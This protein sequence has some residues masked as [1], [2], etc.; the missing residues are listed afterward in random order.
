MATHKYLG[1]VILLGLIFGAH[2]QAEQPEYTTTIT[3]TH[4][5]GPIG[6]AQPTQLDRSTIENLPGGDHTKMEDF[7]SET[8]PGGVRG[9]QQRV[10][11]NQNEFGI[12]Y[13]VDG[14]LLPP[15]QSEALSE[16][17]SLRN[18]EHI[19][20]LSGALPAQF[21]ERIFSLVDITTRSGAGQPQ[22]DVEIGYGSYR[23]FAPEGS[24][25]GASRDGK[26]RYFMTANYWQT[27]RGLGTPEPK[28]ESTQTQG[29]TD[30]YHDQ[31]HSNNEFV[32]LDWLPNSRNQFS[33][34][35]S[36][37]QSYYQIPVLPASFNPTDSFF[38]PNTTDSFGNSGYNYV[39][40]QTNDTQSESN[41]LIQWVW[42]N[43]ISQAS[44]LKLGFYS[45]YNQVRFDNDPANDL[46]ALKLISGSS[47]SSLF[48]NRHAN[49]SGIQGDYEGDL[50]LHQHFGAGFKLSG[51]LSSGLVQV[52]AQDPNNSGNVLSSSDSEPSHDWM[53]GVYVQDEIK[54]TE[55]LIL[56]AGLR[57]DAAQYHFSADATSHTQWEPRIG[58]SYQP[59]L[60]TRLHLFYARLF[61][62][63][64]LENLHQAFVD[65]Q[66]G[67]TGS[68]DIKPE[69][70]NYYEF[71]V[72]Q[73]LIA[74]QT[75]HATFYYKKS[76]DLLDDAQL[77]NTSLSQPF[78]WAQGYAYG[79]KLS[80]E[81]SLT[82]HIQDFV[83]YAYGTARGKN[84]SGGLFGINPDELP[85][86][87]TYQRLDHVQHHTLSSG[88]IYN[89]EHA[90][91]S[92]MGLFGSGL[93]TGPA[94]SIEL[95]SHLS[96]NISAG[97]RF[98][99]NTAWGGMK[100]SGDVTNIFNNV[101]PITIANGFNGS[102]YAQGR[103]FALHLANEF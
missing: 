26:F 58:L 3:D 50:G 14:L 20:V 72:D 53:E 79:L 45:T 56:N 4:D 22:A 54:W 57:F 101:Y 41:E 47:P 96:F 42:S 43:Q 90:W 1:W 2:A 10:Y 76:T 87:N 82:S 80:L 69:K 18:V 17:L 39:P 15:Q 99:K 24:L 27:D 34:L 61:L 83:N 31:A 93:P 95:P 66:A 94:N 25:S 52:S 9:S 36:S 35:L 84:I 91:A 67:S 28:S 102:Y 11:L 103:A 5:D 8:V 70:A 71:G 7:L 60:G 46:A 62:P 59:M 74:Q 33:L 78:N 6:P 48:E 77:L 81:G 98:N 92:V 88:L 89:E 97:C 29:S 73:G 68:Y 38:N 100:F 32:K 21:G 16:A 51:E 44:R 37:S 30:V 40:S 23:T 86:A 49:A 19:T 85:L 12:R 13:Q 63:P 55:R 65:F 64:P 75:L